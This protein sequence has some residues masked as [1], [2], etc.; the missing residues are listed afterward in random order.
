MDYKK[1]PFEFITS[2]SRLLE[3]VKNELAGQPILALDVESDGLDPHTLKLLLVQVGVPGKAFV[4]DAKLDLVSLKLLLED[5][6]IL[7]LVQNGKFD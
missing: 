5:P 1:P 3:V 4:F 7:K 6:K 2:Q